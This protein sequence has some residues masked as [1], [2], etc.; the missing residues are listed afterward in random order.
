MVQKGIF[1]VAFISTLLM[2]IIVA[3]QN[4]DLAEAN[5]IYP[6]YVYNNPK[7]PLAHSPTIVIQTP[8]NV[9]YH[10][11]SVLFK[12]TAATSLLDSRAELYSIVYYL[13]G[14]ESTAYNATYTVGPASYIWYTSLKLTQGTHTIQ[15][16]AYARNYIFYG[17]GS[18]AAIYSPLAEYDTGKVFFTVDSSVPSTSPSVEALPSVLCK[19]NLSFDC[20]NFDLYYPDSGSNFPLVVYSAGAGGGKSDDINY[21]VDL[22]RNGYCCLWSDTLGGNASTYEAASKANT[23]KL[24]SM[25][26]NTTTF[27]AVTGLRIDALKV[28][29][30]GGSSGGGAMMAINDSRVATII[31][32]VPYYSASLPPV[33]NSQPVLICCGQSDSTSPY[34]TNGLVFYNSKVQNRMIL[35]RVGYA[36]DYGAGYSYELAWLNWLFKGNETALD[37]IL[38]VGSDSSVSRYQQDLDLIGVFHD[39]SSVLASPSFSPSPLIS[40]LFSSSP[41][42]QQQTGFL[43]TS[44]PIEFGYAIVAV[45]VAVVVTILLVYFKR[46]RK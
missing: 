16:I 14:V 19:S 45:L 41:T 44:L 28:A 46:L 38:G 18:V 5:F 15:V 24:F 34:D 22:A 11:N 27:H 25:I 7:A 31:G 36:H 3:A 32:I 30:T 43:G 42:V 4:V 9:T 17:G 33:E 26:F 21:A 23:E 40:P 37:Y 12:F 13:D 6:P 35:E 1:A 20:V 8:Q 39:A 29:L 2:L 10:Q